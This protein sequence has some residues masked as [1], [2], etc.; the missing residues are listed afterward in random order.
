MGIVNMKL[1]NS[2]M[3]N[4]ASAR[5]TAMAARKPGSAERTKALSSSPGVTHMYPGSQPQSPSTLHVHGSNFECLFNGSE[6][7]RTDPH[8]K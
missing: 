4:R 6:S 2:L 5:T 7:R 1:S 3:P 8:Q